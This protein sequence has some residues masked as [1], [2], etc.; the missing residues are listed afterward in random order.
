MRYGVQK[1]YRKK[2]TRY[3]G[4]VFL[5]SFGSFRWA[6]TCW[7][8][9]KTVVP[10]H[11]HLVSSAIRERNRGRASLGEEAFLELPA[12]L[13]PWMLLCALSQLEHSLALPQLS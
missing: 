8:L 3:V 12:V 4:Y 5:Y 9:A 10:N 11:V 7:T 2:E 6:E 1:S 13:M